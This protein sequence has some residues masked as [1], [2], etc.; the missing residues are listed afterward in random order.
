MRDADDR[1]LLVS[2]SISCKCDWEILAP[3]RAWQPVD[4]Y[5]PTGGVA[6]ELDKLLD[7]EYAGEILDAAAVFGMA[8]FELAVCLGITGEPADVGHADDIAIKI[9]LQNSGAASW[10]ASISTIVQPIYWRLI[11]IE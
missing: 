6:P 4:A 2:R 11:Y 9:G 8:T 7:G 1:S 3:S 5:G 10:T